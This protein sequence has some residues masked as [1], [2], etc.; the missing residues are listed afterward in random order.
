[1]VDVRERKRN[2]RK[3]K[4]ERE[5]KGGRK[6]RLS[7]RFAFRE[8]LLYLQLNTSRTHLCVLLTQSDTTGRVVYGTLCRR[9]Y[10]HHTFSF[11]VVRTYFCPFPSLSLEVRLR[12]KILSAALHIMLILHYEAIENISTSE[13][14]C[15]FS[16]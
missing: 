12:E 11:S 9:N 7:R 14:K 2:G 15:F 16:Y 13:K 6:E 4:R 10:G 1:M 5:R 8:T 3:R